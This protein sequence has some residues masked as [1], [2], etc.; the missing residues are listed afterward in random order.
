[1]EQLIAHLVGD[2][3][4]Q[5]DWMANNKTSQS[6]ACFCHAMI[7]GIGFWVIGASWTALFVIISTHFLIDRFRLAKFVVYGKNFLYPF[8]FFELTLWLIGFYPKPANTKFDIEKKYQWNNCQAT[9]YPSETPPFLAVWLL[10]IAD[11]TLH[12]LINFL[13]LKYLT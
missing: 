7:Y 10:I 6:F 5:S 8:F 11:N 12:L 3:L 4:T 2:Y 9:G 1:M 13:A